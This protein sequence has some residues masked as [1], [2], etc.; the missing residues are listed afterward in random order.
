M[1][2]G[3]SVSVQAHH[4]ISR[5]SKYDPLAA[6][7]TSSAPTSRPALD[8]VAGILSL[9]LATSRSRSESRGKPSLIAMVTL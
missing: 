6:L 2:D 3:D 9:A 4:P 7:L 5:P 1:L 8:P